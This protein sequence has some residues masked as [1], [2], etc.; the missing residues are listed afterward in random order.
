MQSVLLARQWG[1]FYRIVCGNLFFFFL[2][3]KKI[4]ENSLRKKKK[5]F[6]TFLRGKKGEYH[7]VIFFY[8]HR[9]C[10]AWAPYSASI[11]LPLLSF[12]VTFS[13]EFCPYL[14]GP[15]LPHSQPQCP[16]FTRCWAAGNPPRAGVWGWQTWLGLCL[17]PRSSS[18][19]TW[20][21]SGLGWR[22]QPSAR[23]AT[24]SLPSVRC[25]VW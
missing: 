15:G 11:S 23:A 14:G 16:S 2:Q 1:A 12:Q 25:Q 6:L 13:C 22:L 5:E 17:A 20:A 10:S 19:Q 8:Q 9:V 18:R 21:G 3:I 7:T 4:L 24:R